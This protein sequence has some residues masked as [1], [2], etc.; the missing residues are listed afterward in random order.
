M[1]VSEFTK[2]PMWRMS[3]R[4]RWKCS[5]VPIDTLSVECCPACQERSEERSVWL[6]LGVR[7]SGRVP[8]GSSQIVLSSSDLSLPFFFS[9]PLKPSFGSTELRLSGRL[10]HVNETRKTTS[11]GGAHREPNVYQM[12]WLRGLRDGGCIR[13]LCHLSFE[14]PVDEGRAARFASFVLDAASGGFLILNLPRSS[15][16]FAI[17]REARSGD[18]SQ[19]AISLALMS[20]FSVDGEKV[21]C[22]QTGRSA[23]WCSY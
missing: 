4:D 6:L 21:I 14:T 22:K 11:A 18:Q 7:E 5:R 12:G 20:R 13:C 8:F 10:K 1:S 3:M 19:Y 2:S 23:D 17:G 9:F 16:R 15:L